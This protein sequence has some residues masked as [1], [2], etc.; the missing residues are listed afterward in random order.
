MIVKGVE[1]RDEKCPSRPCWTP[2]Y[3]QHQALSGTQKPRK[4]KSCTLR[5]RHGCPELKAEGRQG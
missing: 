3:Y 2:G 4:Q 5:D 1:C